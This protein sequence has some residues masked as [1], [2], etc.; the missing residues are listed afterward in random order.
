MPGFS[1]EDVC[2]LFW[3]KINLEVTGWCHWWYWRYFNLVLQTV[4]TSISHSFGTFVSPASTAPFA[5][6]HLTEPSRLFRGFISQA[7][8]MY[9]EEWFGRD[10][11]LIFEITDKFSF[12]TASP[13]FP[14]FQIYDVVFCENHPSLGKQYNILNAKFQP[15]HRNK[16]EDCQYQ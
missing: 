4:T 10:L 3:T 6:S 14:F 13:H 1:G 16:L 11:C 5:R 9:P 2:V 7:F 12:F 15:F 8:V